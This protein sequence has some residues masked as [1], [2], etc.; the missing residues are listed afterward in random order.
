MALR[1]PAVLCPAIGQNPVQQDGVLLKERQHPI[2]E[3]FRGGDRRLPVIQ[4]RE[5]DLAVRIDERLL[6]NTPHV[7]ER[8]HVEGVLGAAVAGTL[9]LEF[10]VGFFVRLRLLQGY[11]LSFRQHQPLLG[12]LR[13]QRLEPL[14]HGLQIMSEL[15]TADA[16]GRDGQC[17]LAQFI[18]HP[19]LTPGWL[20]H[21]HLHNRLFH[22]RRDAIL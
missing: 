1:R 17:L 4:L 6:I 12:H 2:I 14:A 22:L 15:D 21:R 13:F 7:L 3:E 8:A 20:G 16:R 18:R 5:A 9:T 11:D 19:H 10:P